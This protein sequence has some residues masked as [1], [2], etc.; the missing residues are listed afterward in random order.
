MGGLNA[1]AAIVT[2]ASFF[3]AIWQFLASRRARATEREKIAQQRERLRTAVSAAV[4]GAEAAD[5]I[6]QRSKDSS[7]TPAELASIARIARM[8][9]TLVARQLE[10][11]RALLAGW[12]YGRLTTSSPASAAVPSGSTSPGTSP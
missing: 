7:A 8:N 2:V 6:V 4:A 3:L 10:D 12:Q 9:L 1:A 11:E 5:L